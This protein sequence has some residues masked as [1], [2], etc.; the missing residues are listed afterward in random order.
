MPPAS[1][2]LVILPLADDAPPAEVVLGREGEEH[3]GVGGPV[4]VGAHP[5][6]LQVAARRRASTIGGPLHALVAGVAAGGHPQATQP[7]RLHAVWGGEAGV[8]TTC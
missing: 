3:Y 7:L 1:R 5:V 2:L 8:S 4:V 6:V